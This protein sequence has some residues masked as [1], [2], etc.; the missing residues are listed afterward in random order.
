MARSVLV[1]G[2]LSF[3]TDCLCLAL[4]ATKQFDEVSYCALPDLRAT[5]LADCFLL[6]TD[7]GS[8]TALAALKQVVSV[9]GTKPIVVLRGS[10]GG[11]DDEDPVDYFRGGVQG[12]LLWDLTLA[13]VVEALDAALCGN[14]VCAPSKAKQLFARLAALGCGDAEA[15]IHGPLSRRERQVL[16]LIADGLSNADIARRLGISV[17]TVK[18]HVHSILRKLKVTRRT[19]A[20]RQADYRGWLSPP[21]HELAS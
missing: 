10:R 12:Y 14:V 15:P 17:F 2:E 5:P 19:A 13:D 11:W 18:N 21:R 16:V 9:A 20:V 7:S 1:V 3:E 4:R 6:T 8:S